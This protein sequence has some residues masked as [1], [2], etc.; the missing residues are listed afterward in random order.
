MYRWSIEENNS[1]SKLHKALKHL[2]KKKIIT[3]LMYDTV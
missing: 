2:D 3:H 1:E